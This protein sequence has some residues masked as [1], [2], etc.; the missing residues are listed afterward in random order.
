MSGYL[1]QL[2]V[3]VWKDLL[4]E[5]RSRERVASMGAFAVLAGVLFNFS[6][7][8]T[9]VRPQDVA[10]GLIWMTLVF[11]GLLGVGRTFHIE[12]QDGALQ[13]ILMS[14]TPKDAVFLAK[15]VSN[16]VL[17]FAVSL[18][19]LGVFA[20]FFGVDIRANLGWVVLVLGLGSLGFVAVATLFAAMSTGT[21]MSDTLLPILVFP[22]LVPMIVFG[23]GSTGRLMA[24]RPF[25]EVEGN[26]R[27]LGAFAFAA[28][29]A[30]AVLFRFVVEE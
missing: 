8:T 13:G 26:V 30:G 11:G 17:L 6:I 12:A 20:L 23:V 16:F 1:G 18:L 3:I 7:D 9:A 24:G 22:L 2:S 14:P 27:M 28:V 15:V 29:A 4:L 25:S 5:L 19:V 21:R 10:A